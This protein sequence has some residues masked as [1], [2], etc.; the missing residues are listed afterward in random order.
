MIYS[1]FHHPNLYTIHM[2]HILFCSTSNIDPP[3]A[4]SPPF[5]T[6]EPSSAPSRRESETS[7]SSPAMTTLTS[8]TSKKRRKT[9]SKD[10]DS[11]YN[12]LAALNK[13]ISTAKDD[14]CAGLGDYLS[15]KLRQFPPYQ[16]A[17]ATKRIQD[18]L[19]LSLELNMTHLAIF[20]TY[21]QL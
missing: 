13:E 8:T 20:T 2:V 12:E 15:S 4:S 18:C 19:I 6:E 17:L 5:M 3:T 16:R 11:I 7:S 10:L 21:Q 9:R 1:V 14:E